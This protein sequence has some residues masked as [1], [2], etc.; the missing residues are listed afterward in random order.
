MIKYNDFFLQ[1]ISAD[2]GNAL[3]QSYLQIK[4]KHMQKGKYGYLLLK[5]EE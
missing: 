5:Q 1:S 2:D 4:Q 3:K